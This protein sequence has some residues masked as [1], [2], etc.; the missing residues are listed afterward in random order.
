MKNFI[1]NKIELLKEYFSKKEEVLLAFVFGSQSKGTP[2]LESD[3]D[4]AVYFKSDEYFELETNKEYPQEHQIW[5]D[6]EKILQKEVDFVVLNRAKPSLVFSILNSGLPLVIKDRKLYLKLLIKT[7]Y[8]AI[9]FWQFTQEFYKISKRSKSLSEE[10]KAI[11]LQHLRFL[12]LEF[13]D[14]ENF[15]N[16]TYQDYL[17]NRSK[18][19]EIERLIE[20]LVMSAIDISKIILAS[21]KRE[22][23]QTYKE[24]I[25]NFVIRFMDEEKAQKFSQFSEL[26]NIIAYE[27]L[28][29]K[30]EKIK[31]FISEALEL[32]PIFIEKEKQ[33]V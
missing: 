27:Y 2:T 19:R 22:I 3:F 23:P 24:T 15:K 32:Y 4:I 6:L 11:L 33:M 14:L 29:I 13:A 30:W 26:R 25:F 5:Q 8:E 16:L 12:E 10:D 28:D 1:E 9:D 31:K 7:H 20:N 18:R 17:E 21:E